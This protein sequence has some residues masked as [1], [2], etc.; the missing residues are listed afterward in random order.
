MAVSLT[1]L[2]GGL[3][4]QHEMF[5]TNDDGM[6]FPDNLWTQT[7]DCRAEEAPN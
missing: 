1:G 3:L 7:G 4:V 2:V 5:L 6:M